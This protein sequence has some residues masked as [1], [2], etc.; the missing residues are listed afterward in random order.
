MFRVLCNNDDYISQIVEFQLV[1]KLLIMLFSR[2]YIY[3]DL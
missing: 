2:N 3:I 1:R